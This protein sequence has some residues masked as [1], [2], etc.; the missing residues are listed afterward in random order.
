MRAG[1]VLPAALSGGTSG[2]PIS[3]YFS[4]PL[5]EK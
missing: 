1:E 5:E 4:A 2:G 3:E